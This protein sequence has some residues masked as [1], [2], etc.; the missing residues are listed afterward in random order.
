MTRNPAPAEATR[1]PPRPL[2]SAR[3]PPAT[4]PSLPLSKGGSAP[5]PG[6]GPTVGAGPP[7][8]PGKRARAEGRTPARSPHLGERQLQPDHVGLPG[9]PPLLVGL[10]QVVIDGGGRVVAR[11]AGRVRRWEG[12]PGGMRAPNLRGCAPG[13]RA[14]RRA[15][16]VRPAHHISAVC[17]LAE[18]AGATGP[19]PRSA[20]RR[21]KPRGAERRP[22]SD[23][24]LR[25]NFP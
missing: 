15:R 5:A 9:D 16:R 12:R 1:G 24:T 2:R 7:A 19:E 4:S 22:P 14:R 8:C 21:R 13:S 18:R 17:R 10:M 25:C 23:A 3:G 11:G 20:R 6:D